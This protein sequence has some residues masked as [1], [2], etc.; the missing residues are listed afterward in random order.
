M[1][2]PLRRYVAAIYKNNTSLGNMPARYGTNGNYVVKTPPTGTASRLVQQ[3]KPQLLARRTSLWGRCLEPPHP[4]PTAIN[5]EQ[6]SFQAVEG[7]SYPA[8]KRNPGAPCVPRVFGDMLTAE[9]IYF[10]IRRTRVLSHVP[11]GRWKKEKKKT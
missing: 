11:T 1:Y 5:S 7:T 10:L 4:P 2:L 6:P 8:D 3:Y 9:S